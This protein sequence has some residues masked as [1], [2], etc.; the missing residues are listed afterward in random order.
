MSDFCI[1]FTVPY[2]MVIIK[3]STVFHS[4]GCFLS[5]HAKGFCSQN[6]ELDKIKKK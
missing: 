5:Q 6:V 4:D 3:S 1:H 2:D